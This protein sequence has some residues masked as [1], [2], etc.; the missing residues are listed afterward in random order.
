MK[1]I[2]FE[3]LLQ[4]GEKWLESKIQRMKNLLK[5]AEPDEALYREIMLSLGYPK[6]KVQFL[7]LALL[8]PWR[9]IRRL[10][11][12]D[13]IEKALLY[14]AGFVERIDGLPEDFDLS[15]KMD[16]SVWDFKGIRPVNYPDKR[17]K[18]ISY[19]LAD[20]LPSGLVN[21]FIK[22][23]KGQRRVVLSPGEAKKCISEI[24]NFQEIGINR[25]REIFFNIIL[26]FIIA[27]NNEPEIIKSLIKIFELHPPLSENSITTR[28]SKILP[29]KASYTQIAQST[30]IY[31]GILF[32]MKKVE[33]A[34]E[35]NDG[36]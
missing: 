28:F 21:F 8:L 10:K 34:D 12:K 5:I 36:H 24:M 18:G 17:I 23:I 31:F 27:F 4:L 3:F 14:R 13:K 20:A 30:K 9:E 22:K 35:D 11:D 6:N 2:N 29:E 26:P 19:L 25:K 33:N 7:E 15:L 16:K 32:Y 1:Q